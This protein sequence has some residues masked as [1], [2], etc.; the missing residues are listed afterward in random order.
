MQ[1]WRWIIKYSKMIKKFT[2]S[3]RPQ[4]SRIF[5]ADE[6]FVNC[7]GKQNYF[8]DII[9]KGTRYLVSTHYSTK[10]D[11]KSAKILFLKTKHIPLT[12]FTDG[13]QG[14]KKAYR[15]VWGKNKRSQ[16]REINYHRAHARGTLFPD[17]RQAGAL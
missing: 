4:L 7:K 12:L 6:I 10:R 9:D 17:C 16:D 3:L 11:S 15:K 1:I 8:W 5:H 2:D 14:Y 13:L